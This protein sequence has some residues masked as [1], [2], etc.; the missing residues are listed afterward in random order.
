MGKVIAFE[1]G[2]IIAFSAPMMVCGD[3]EGWPAGALCRVVSNR[4]L[5]QSTALWQWV[6]SRTAGYLRNMQVNR[7]VLIREVWRWV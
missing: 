1:V 7:L 4:R 5:G 6:L 2:D 3:F